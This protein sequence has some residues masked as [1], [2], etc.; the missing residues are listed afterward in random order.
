[1][2]GP[3]TLNIHICDVGG[4]CADAE[5]HLTVFQF[6]D[7]GA[8][9]VGDGNSTVGAPVT[10]W[11]AQW[12]NANSLTGGNAN[13]S[14][15]GFGETTTPAPAVCGGTFNAGPGNSASFSGPLPSF[16]GVVVSSS[17]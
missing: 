15:K 4:A 7:H 11:G 6:L 1:D 16:M 14:F 12:A 17:I 5:S 10:F 3:Q 13:H 8:F 2:L 9:V